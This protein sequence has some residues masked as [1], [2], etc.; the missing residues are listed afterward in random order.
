MTDATAS[1]PHERL[2]VAA[3]RGFERLFP[4]APGLEVVQLPG[5]LLAMTGAPAPDLNCGVVWCLSDAAFVARRLA[6]CLRRRG[7]PGILLVADAAHGPPAIDAP[8]AG[9][10]RRRGCR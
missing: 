9:S 1:S 4:S 3:G 5:G 2:W 8:A 6:E 10:S 7:L